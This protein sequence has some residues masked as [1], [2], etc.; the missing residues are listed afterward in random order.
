MRETTALQLTHSIL[1]GGII[2]GRGELGI[3]RI[4][5]LWVMNERMSNEWIHYEQYFWDYYQTWEEQHEWNE[6]CSDDNTWFV[7]NEWII[8]H[9]L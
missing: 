3:N 1:R 2:H 6:W 7:M 4:K 5:Y 9:G 8:N